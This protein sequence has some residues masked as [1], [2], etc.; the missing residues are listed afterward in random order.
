MPLY[1]RV[2]TGRMLLDPIT[3]Y[4]DEL[5]YPGSNRLGFGADGGNSAGRMTQARA[6]TGG[7]AVLN[8]RRNAYLLNLEMTGWSTGSLAAAVGFLLLGRWSRPGAFFASLPAR[9]SRGLALYWVP[10][11]DYGARYWYQML[12]P[13][14]PDCPGDPAARLGP[15]DLHTTGEWAGRAA[16]AR[17]GDCMRIRS[18]RSAA[19][20]GRDSKDHSP[21]RN[22]R[23]G[24]PA[25]R[26][27]S[28][29]R[30]A[31][32]RAWRRRNHFISALYLGCDSERAHAAASP[33]PSSLVNSMRRRGDASRAPSLDVR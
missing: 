33:R 20:A 9:D 23:A 26:K 11:A 12:I 29:R 16:V 24:G 22:E 28:S 13:G 15:C 7:E 27:A 4:F 1:N 14:Y 19:V 5:Y 3:K 6:H 30:R 31:R 18:A 8:S 2:L 17:R 21:S 25:A 10:R 32:V